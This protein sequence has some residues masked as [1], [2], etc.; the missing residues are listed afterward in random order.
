MVR[1]D[2][3]NSALTGRPCAEAGLGDWIDRAA[4]DWGLAVRRLPITGRADQLLITHTVDP[5]APWLL[6]D[7]HMDTVAV[8]GMTIDPFGG[9]LRDG[10]VYGRGACDT[11]GTGAAMLW[12]LR[13]YAEQGG[14]PNNIVLL[15]SVD[16]EVGMLGISSFLANDYAALGFVPSGVIVGEPTELHPVIAHNGLI[17]W[18]VTTHGVAAHSSVPHQ[19]SSA[20][21][22]MMRVVQAIETDYIPS[23]TAEHELTGH[24]VCSINMIQG[25]SAP[26]IIPDRCVIDVD[27][28]VVPG[29]EFESVMH[30]L[31][32]ILDRVKHDEP[33]LDYTLDVST[34]HPPL[35]PEGS[36]SLLAS[37]IDVLAQQGL[38][39]L[40]LGAPF[41]THAGYFCQAGIPTL[42]LGP[43]EAHKAHTKD[44]YISTEQLDRGAEVYL[45]LMH[46]QIG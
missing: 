19:G 28:R 43:G 32:Q 12:A 36:E 6:F 5:G 44:E 3:V 17:R 38:P 22:T 29:E 10:R 1:I 46:S 7:S 25:G 8:E 41:S 20:I 2:S 31:V 24:A 45:G 42:V 14:G 23:L 11:K 4:Q 33:S 35:L 30:A 18:Q 26:N 37:T 15:F 13:A 21:S 34:T 9:E 27:R 16:E 40:S 39:G